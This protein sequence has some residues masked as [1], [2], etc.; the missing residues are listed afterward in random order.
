MTGKINDFC[1][2]SAHETWVGWK[3]SKHV[4]SKIVSKKCSGV[5]MRNFPVTRKHPGCKFD[6]TC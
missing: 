3:Y 4:E 5:Y 6:A 2:N 1:S